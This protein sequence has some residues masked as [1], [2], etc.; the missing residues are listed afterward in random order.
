MKIHLY[1]NEVCF[2][3]T[4]VAQWVSAIALQAEGWVFQ[5]QQRQTCRKNR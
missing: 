2:L 3:T 1:Y 5:S 4:A